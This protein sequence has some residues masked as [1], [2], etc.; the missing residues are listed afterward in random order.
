MREE[1]LVSGVLD[2][3]KLLRK[4]FVLDLERQR[5]IDVTVRNSDDDSRGCSDLTNMV[6]LEDPRMIFADMR[7]HATST[8]TS[9][10]T[11]YHHHHHRRHDKYR[12]QNNNDCTP[13]NT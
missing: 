11:R 2:E 12:A 7:L 4:F 13:F 10:P 6:F 9:T 1:L 5:E 3:D 8:P